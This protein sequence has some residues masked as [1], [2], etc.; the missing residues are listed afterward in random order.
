MNNSQNQKGQQDENLEA[1]LSDL[2][3]MKHLNNQF[4]KNAKQPKAAPINITSATYDMGSSNIRTGSNIQA[5]GND[6][7]PNKP[8]SKGGDKG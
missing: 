4:P 2:K 1:I 7:L 8:K 3:R 6:H 5:V